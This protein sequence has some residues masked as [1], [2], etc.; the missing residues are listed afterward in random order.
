MDTNPL[1]RELPS[2]DQLLKRLDA[3][4][5]GYPRS[6]VVAEVRRVLAEA[7]ENLRVSSGLEQIVV[8]RLE[9]LA[10]PSLRRVINA[11]GVV[12]HTNLGRAP[13]PRFEPIFGYSNLEYDLESGRRGKRD[14][15]TGALLERLLGCPAIAVNNNAAAVYLA[16]HELAAGYE[17]IVSRGE[18][19][20]IG[21]G[22]RIPDIMARSGATLREVGTTNKTSLDDY[23]NAVSDRTRLILRVHPS[24]FR[25]EGF[26]HK[27]ALTELAALAKERRIPLYEDLGSGCIVDLKPFG[28]YEP[29]VSDSIR[30]GVDLV[31]FS[32]DKLLGGPQSGIVAGRADLVERLRRNPM[33][34]AFRLDKLICQA[35]EITLR[36]LVFERWD[37]I[38][39][40]QMLSFSLEQIRSRAEAFQQRIVGYTSRLVEGESV[41]GGGATPAQSMPTVL[42]AIEAA[43]VIG[44]ERKLRSGEPPVIARIVDDRLVVDLR[45]V[46]PDEEDALLRA[47]AV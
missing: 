1:L 13:L 4:V 42:I 37:E 22:F 21:D 29:L 5:V 33:F 40:L 6:M 17:V 18:L 31:S 26:T 28:L 46:R 25:I 16:L 32:T 19:I 15:H 41:I 12:L 43:D 2:V 44:L 8:A 34:R 47:I 39:A 10:R 45:T 24:N 9:A 36:S 11:T 20:E 38:P 14:A 23:R 30:A 35:L 7:R 27:P 3:Q